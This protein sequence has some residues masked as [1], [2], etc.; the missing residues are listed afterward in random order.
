M[1]AKATSESQ[2]AEAPPRGQP[3][4]RTAHS[5]RH[6]PVRPFGPC[7]D[8]RLAG[9]RTHEQNGASDS[10]SPPCPPAILPHLMLPA[11]LMTTAHRN[12]PSP[13]TTTTARG[14]K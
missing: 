8:V 10:G 12:R 11:R 9:L 2:P 6:D 7:V 13:L 5:P 1:R 4:I 14:R 3:A